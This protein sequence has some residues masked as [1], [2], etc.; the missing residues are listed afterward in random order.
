MAFSP[1]TSHS[2]LVYNSLYKNNMQDSDGQYFLDLTY[3]LRLS[4]SKTDLLFSANNI[5]NRSQYVQQFSNEI[6]LVQSRF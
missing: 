5:L 6:E 2:L 4:K 1:H 3:R